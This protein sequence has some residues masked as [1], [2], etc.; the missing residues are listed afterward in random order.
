M[1]IAA[2]AVLIAFAVW[3]SVTRHRSTAAPSWLNRMSRVTPVAAFALGAG[4]I[5]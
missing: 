1:R 5:W 3:R 4:L 2:G